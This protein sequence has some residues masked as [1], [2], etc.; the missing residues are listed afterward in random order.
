MIPARLY[1]LI[2]L[3]SFLSLISGCGDNGPQRYAVSGTATFDG[4]P[5]E[6]G[7]ISFVPVDSNQSPE[8]GVIENGKFQ[9]QSLA[10]AKSVQIR[11]SRALPPERQDNPEMG[12][13]YEDY[14]PAQFNA[15]T[16]LQAEVTPS[17]ANTFTFELKSK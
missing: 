13:L 11:G 4:Q 16:T 3:G 6:R 5:I 2:L 12:L 10:G 8:G 9:F 1:T 17:G 7:E 14:I 15:S